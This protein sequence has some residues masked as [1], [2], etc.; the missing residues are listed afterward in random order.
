M[1]G[2]CSWL[3][4]IQP[5]RNCPNLMSCVWDITNYVVEGSMSI[6]LP[7]GSRELIKTVDCKKY[8]QVFN[9]VKILLKPQQPC[10]FKEEREVWSVWKWFKYFSRRKYFLF[11]T[12]L[13][14]ISSKVKIARLETS[15]GRKHPH[16][17]GLGVC[18]NS[19]CAGFHNRGH[20][21]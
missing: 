14:W 10:V 4:Q 19:R 9:W 12:N 2:K 8:F 21:E 17:A 18:S 15:M 6:Y 13:W 3:S 5:K 20:S 7:T 1:L 11:S 16:G